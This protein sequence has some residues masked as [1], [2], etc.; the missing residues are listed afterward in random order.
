M[1]RLTTELDAQFAESSKLEVE[2]R[3]NL[4]RTRP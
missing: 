4:E 2:I 1:K 3:R